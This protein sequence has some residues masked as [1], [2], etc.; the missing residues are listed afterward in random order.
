MKSYT[1]TCH[2]VYNYGASL[3]AYSLQRYLNSQ[4]VDSIIIDYR[5]GYLSGHYALWK[6]D[7]PRY[8]KPVI[9]TLYKIVKLP[10]RI[11]SLKKKK[12]FDRFTEKYLRL[13]P[14]TYSD[15]SGLRNL[16][17]D[18]FIAG[19]DQIWNTLFKNGH[20]EAFY[21]SFVNCGRK[22]S[23][24]ASFATDRIFGGAESFIRKS[25]YGLDAISVRESSALKLLDEL[26]I[27]DGTLV[28][29]PVLLTTKTEWDALIDNFPKWNGNDY[30]LIYDCENDK[31]LMECALKISRDKSLPIFC[32]GSYSSDN[33]WSKDLRDSGPLEFIYYIRNAKYVVSNSFHA[34][35]FSL[36]YSKDFYVVNRSSEINSRMIDLLEFIG[37][38][39]RLIDSPDSVDYTPIDFGAVWQKLEPLISHSKAFLAAQ[40]MAA[41]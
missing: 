7:S 28:A 41:K 16:K 34:T 13:S 9:R 14:Q 25:L 38:K 11:R 17:A 10:G 5:P 6:C 39:P 35:I 2:N 12:I 4:E 21:L 29:D 23:Y 31:T 22:I 40:I 36:I 32:I 30:I 8:N 24:A 20:D 18:L 19:S 15:I 1:I 33:Y 27:S 26:G 3:Q 37:H